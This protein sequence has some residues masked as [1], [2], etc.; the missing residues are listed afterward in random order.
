MNKET[1]IFIW[2]LIFIA[3]GVTAF[4]YDMKTFNWAFLDIVNVII[5][6][7]LVVIGMNKINKVT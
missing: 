2:G 3:V 5:D 1:R 7:C 6:F 4:H